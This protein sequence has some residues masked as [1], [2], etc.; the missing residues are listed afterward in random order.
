[1]LVSSPCARRLLFFPCREIITQQAVAC[2]SP[3][4]RAS[5]EVKCYFFVFREILANHFQR[6]T[7]A[8]PLLSFSFF[9]SRCDVAN[10]YRADYSP[11]LKKN[12]AICGG[13]RTMSDLFP[14]TKT[15]AYRAD[16]NPFSSCGAAFNAM[17]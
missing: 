7:M 8:H 1:M 5:T 14:T 13:G 2:V 12:A 11:S 4:A 6:D 16:Y 9:F 15:T 10:A 17:P 3:C